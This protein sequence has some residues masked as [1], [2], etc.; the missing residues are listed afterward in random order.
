[1]PIRSPPLL[2][3][4]MGLKIGRVNADSRIGYMD[5]E[6]DISEQRFGRSDRS[7]EARCG[8]R[9]IGR[10]SAMPSQRAGD[11]GEPAGAFLAYVVCERAQ[12]RKSPPAHHCLRLAF[13]PRLMC[14]GRSIFFPPLSICLQM[15]LPSTRAAAMAARPPSSQLFFCSS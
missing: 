12:N 2:L 13:R 7:L 5:F 1:M 9:T 3:L 10:N 14:P 4:P 15:S 11:K 6:I 8:G